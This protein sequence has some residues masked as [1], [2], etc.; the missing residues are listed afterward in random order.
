[1]Q[2]ESGLVLDIESED[3]STLQMDPS[4]AQSLITLEPINGD[5]VVFP[6]AVTTFD[7][8][9]KRMWIW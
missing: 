4:D 6:E 1:M 3:P 7:H 5:E 8:N 2:T 9:F